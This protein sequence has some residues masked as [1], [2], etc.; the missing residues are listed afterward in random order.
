MENV[1][2][3]IF[4]ENQNLGGMKFNSIDEVTVDFVDQFFDGGFELRA[5]TKEQFEEFILGDEVYVEDFVND[6]FYFENN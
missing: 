2:I 4:K 3:G 5:L 1:Y 6:N